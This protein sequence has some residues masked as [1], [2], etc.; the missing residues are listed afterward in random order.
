MCHFCCIIFNT[1]TGFCLY[2]DKHRN[3][4]VYIRPG[5]LTVLLDPL[6]CL[7]TSNET[8]DMLI[9]Q[10]TAPDNFDKRFGSRM[11]WMKFS[12]R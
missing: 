5:E 9:V 10:H 4:T 12:D 11:T 2:Q 1:M 6:S 3:T 7:E 8:L